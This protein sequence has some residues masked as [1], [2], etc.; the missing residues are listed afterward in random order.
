M[1][2]TLN[3]TETFLTIPFKVVRK[4]NPENLHGLPLHSKISL[5]GNVYEDER[6]KRINVH[7]ARLTIRPSHS[8]RDAHISKET[9]DDD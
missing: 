7:F 3:M 4:D 2:A 1:E 8:K 9:D 5:Q 6:Q